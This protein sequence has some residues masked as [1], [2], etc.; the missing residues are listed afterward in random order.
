VL[1]SASGAM[2]EDHDSEKEAERKLMDILFS[3][4]VQ[5]FCGGCKLCKHCLSDRA[6]PVLISAAMAMPEDQDSEKEAERLVG[7][8]TYSWD[9]Q[10][11]CGVCGHLS[12]SVIASPVITKLS[13]Q[14]FPHKDGFFF[15]F[16]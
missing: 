14:S 12:H 7:D 15:F 2:S 10:S 13:I 6:V 3:W 4:D 11:S 8:I 5:P 16:T 9:L 1:I